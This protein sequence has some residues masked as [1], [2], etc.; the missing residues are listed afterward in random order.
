MNSIPEGVKVSLPGGWGMPPFGVHQYLAMIIVAV[1]LWILGSFWLGM[2]AANQWVGSWQNQMSLHVYI[3][4]TDAVDSQ[5]LKAIAEELKALPEVLDVQQ[6]ELPHMRQWLQ[7]WMGNSLADVSELVEALPVT[8]NVTLHGAG[9]DFTVDDIRDVASR[10]GGSLNEEEIQLLKVNDVLDQV[11]VMAWFVTMMLSLAM[12]LIISNTLRMILLARA[13]E[14]HLMRL[15]GAKEWFVRMP[16]ILEGLALGAA[17]GVLAWLLLWPL[18]WIAASWLEA[19][20]I[21]LNLWILLISLLPGGAFMGLA[22][23]VI[24]TARL[25]SPD[26]SES[27]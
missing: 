10:F 20:A 15:L 21:D 3:P 5:R 16:F 22:G 2:Q 6:I 19:G 9:G 18:D 23:A 25:D 27:T 7:Q 14:V 26:S 1:A 12:A 24:A 8:F 17:S 13:D 11:R 4:Q